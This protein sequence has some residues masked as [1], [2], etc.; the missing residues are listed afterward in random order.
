MTD[1][2]RV[3]RYRATLILLVAAAA[4]AAALIPAAATARVKPCNGSPELCERPFNLVTLPGSHNSMSNSEQSWKMPNQTYSIPHQLER[5]VR[6]LLIDTH[7]GKPVTVAGKP[8]VQD[9]HPA[10]YDPAK[11]DRMYLCHA[12]CSLGASDLIATF[13]EVRAFLESNPREVLLF[14]VEDEVE[15][16]DFADALE[17]SGLIDFAYR[18]PTTEAS[19]WPT[20]GEM[21]RTGQRTVFLHESN[22][23]GPSWYPAA[24]AGSLQETPYQWPRSSPDNPGGY[25]GIQFLTDPLALAQSCVPNRGGTMAPLF[26]MNHWVSG[27]GIP[28]SS[29]NTVPR[30]AMAEVVN[31]KQALVARARTCEQERGIKPTILAVDF[32]GTGDTLGAARELNGVKATPYL[33]FRKRP[34]R[35]VTK[36]GRKAVYRLTVANIGDAAGRPKVCAVPPR[37]LAVKRCATATIAPGRAKRIVFRLK[38]KRRAGGTGRVRFTVSG[39]GDRL[40]TTARLKARPIPKHR[41]RR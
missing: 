7:Y 35:A 16:D 22:R 2:A 5:G 28:G 41:N 27:D 34:K 31:S 21:I 37:R 14:D 40:T 12:L 20:L 6:A 30:P 9:V 33:E 15:P 4:V 25:T 13:G 29:D 23:A 24:Y 26:L 19:G 17:E 8:S 18:G 36:A 32:F 3:P 39:A 38:T 11:G 1:F 10:D